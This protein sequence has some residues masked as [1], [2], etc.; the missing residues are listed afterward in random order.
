MSTTD[1]RQIL[2]LMGLTA[3]AT[4]KANIAKAL[5][6]PANNRTGTIQDVEHIVVL[7]QENRPFDHHFGAL[8]GVRGFNDPRAI[9]IHLPLQG[10]GSAP[11]SVF[12]QP[13]GPANEAAGFSVPP[14]N[15]GGPPTGVEVIPPFRVNPESVSPGLTSLGL[16]YLPGTSHSWNHTHAAWNQGQYDG[17]A[18]TNGPMAMS[19]FTRADIPYHYALADAFTVADAYHSSIMGPTNPNR[20]YMWAGCVGNLSNLGPGGTDGFGAGPMTYNGLSI[21][22]AY[23]TFPTFP[24]VLQAAGVSWKIYQDLAGQTFSPDFGDG[25]GNS[26]AGNFTDN[27]VLYFNQYATAPSS[28]PLFQDGCTGTDITNII[29]SGGAPESQWLA[30]AEHLFDQ[31]RS[32]VQNGTLPRV[33]WIVAP[34]G[35]TEHS[36]WPINYGAWYISQVLDILVSNPDMFSST[37]LLINYDEA[38]GSFDHILP[39]TPPPSAAFGASTVSTVNEVVTAAGEPSGFQ[40]GPIGLNCRVPFLAVSPW[41]KGGYVNSQVFDHTSVIQ[42]IEKR[43]GVSE[44]NISPWRRAVC[45][46]LTSMFDFSKPN[47]ASS[48]LPSTSSFLPSVNELAG[49]NVNT[50]QPTLDTVILGVPVQEPGVRPARALPYELNVHAAVNAST[51]SV[52]LTFFNTGSAAVVFQ[53][54]S[55]NPAD[56][57]RTYTVEPKKQLSDSWNAVSSY[58]LAVY[59]P[60]GFVRFFNGSI[61]SGAAVL[62][63]VSSYQTQGRGSILW[64][65]ANLASTPSHVSVLDAYKDKTVTSRLLQPGQ[66]LNDKLQLAPFHG[67]YDLIVTVA[68]DPSFKY[69]LAGHVETGDD[70]S[71][72]PAMGGLVS[73]AG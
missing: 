44:P 1:R 64:Q 16:T 60:N 37:V 8:R 10:G 30:W 57:V 70:S 32:D 55:G 23:W 72:D 28:S 3:M 47:H 27:S 15:F 41:S 61:G 73:L 42:F 34:A 51:G 53:V 25:T 50:F 26:F 67:W 18:N 11:A 48:G 45:G 24:E 4:F 20:T 62:D 56:V 22:N 6:I 29:P 38:D 46:D 7:M 58:D 36:D 31:F 21:N 9:N 49:G 13:A 52:T 69:R 2:Q 12:L 59:G 65:I 54:R 35:Y 33:S 68:G 39:P 66:T 63:V 17:W 19:Y 71:S 43:F 40:S 14:G 5:A